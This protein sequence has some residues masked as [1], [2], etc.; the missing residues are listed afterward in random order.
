MKEL[1]LE[2]MRVIDSH[3]YENVGHDGQPLLDGEGGQDRRGKSG[4]VTPEYET[5]FVK[6]D[7]FSTAQ[8]ARMI[9]FEKINLQGKDLTDFAE[10]LWKPS[11]GSLETFD[12]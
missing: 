1:F 12:L 4:S 7:L 8:C 9:F 3:P 5:I 6:G 11:F 2:Q 10:I